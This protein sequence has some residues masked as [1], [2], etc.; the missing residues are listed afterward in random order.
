MTLPFSKYQ[1]LG[2]DFVVVDG[3]ARAQFIARAAATA[4]CDRH[5]GVGA[6][7]VLLVDDSDGTPRMTVVNADGT[8][9]QMCGN[10][11][12]CV[13]LHL[14]RAGKVGTSFEVQTDTGPHRCEILGDGRVR[15][16]MA[17]ASLDPASLPL[18]ADGP[19]IDG[20]YDVAG[21]ALKLTAVS[22][23]NPH[24]VV[25]DLP[26]AARAEVGPAL[27]VHPDFEQGVN[28]GFATRLD[29]T[30]FEL[31]V[32]ERG[33]GWTRACGTGA[34][35]AAVAAVETGRAPRGVDLSIELPGGELVVHVGEPG[36]RV[37]MTGPAAHV[38]T[39]SYG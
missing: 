11:L 14:H 37:V 28:A 36:T 24:A 25:F 4:I 29:E 26:E 9:P 6:D 39:G 20:G 12:R 7:G 23:G 38:F 1:G 30:H 17:P 31:V 18:R 3:D 5:L 8:T 34:C 2:N 32:H 33:A 27:S 22:M 16:E 13:A 10:G 15:I 19:V 35:A 21:H